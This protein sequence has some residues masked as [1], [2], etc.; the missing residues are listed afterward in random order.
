MIHFNPIKIFISLIFIVLI[1]VDSIGQEVTQDS[2]GELILDFQYTN[3]FDKEVEYYAELYN[4]D[5]TFFLYI[6]VTK[7]DYLYIDYIPSD[8]YILKL[9]SCNDVVSTIETISIYDN[10]TTTVYVSFPFIK[11]KNDQMRREEGYESVII[12]LKHGN[13]FLINESDVRLEQYAFDFSVCYHSTLTPSLS[14]VFAWGVNTSYT[15]FHSDDF[16]FDNSLYDKERFFYMNTS[17]GYALRYSSLN[18]GA[19]DKRG[20]FVDAQIQYNLPMWFRHVAAGK[21]VKQ[22][23][24]GLHRFNDFSAVFRIGYERVSLMVEYRLTNR[25]LRDELFPEL[26]RFSAGIAFAL[27]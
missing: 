21:R 13:D 5:S 12:A 8:E 4:K 14:I 10:Y 25:M 6:E 15:F 26:P 3:T 9:Y 7:E 23:S 18:Q 11:V 19:D 1:S 2:I 17:L 20:F 22:V 16:V 27:P 24:T